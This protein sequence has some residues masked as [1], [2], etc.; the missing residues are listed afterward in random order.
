M[1]APSS[2][3]ILIPA[4]LQ[5]ARLPNKPLAMIGSEPMIV[6]VWRRACETGLGPVVVA[7]GDRDIADPIRQAGGEAI[8]TDPALPSGTDRIAAA[9]RSFDPG[10]RHDAVI[11]IQGD[12]PLLEP[13]TVDAAWR[14]L[15]DDA[16]DIGTVA[17]EIR[18]DDERASLSVVKAVV[19]WRANGRSGRALYFTRAGAPAG[20]GPMY[21][22]I[23]LYTFRR[24][25]LERFVQLPPSPLE[26]QERLE[27]LRALEAGMRIDVA[28]VDTTPLGIDTPADL[29][30]ARRLITS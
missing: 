17:A 13:G 2:P 22:H 4:R 5:A 23:G 6:H 12:L 15:N 11:N 19:A 18:D 14:L 29:E 25:A 27:Q 9:L 24:E 8:L 16:V 30:R 10:G 3:I 21:H 28:R 20:D 1:S 7:C 26:R